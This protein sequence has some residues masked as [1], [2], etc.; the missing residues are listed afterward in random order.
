MKRIA[1]TII[2][3]LLTV[4]SFAQNNNRGKDYDWANFTKYE[5]AN[6]EV[7]T[8][9]VVVFMG[10]SITEY[11]VSQDPDFFI[12]NNFIGRGI[13]GQV[14]MQMLSRFQRDVIELHPKVVVINS[15]TNDIAKNNGNI[16][17]ENVVSGIQSMCELARMHG[18]TPVIASVLPCNRF[19]W[20]QEA[21]PAQDII[22]LNKLI[23]A[24][25]DAAGIM[26]VDYHT[27]MRA[28]DGSLPEVYT[29][30]GC[31]PIIAGYKKMESIVLPYIQKALAL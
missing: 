8:N 11:W 6:A 28:A 4:A 29:Q 10:D 2:M 25:A 16:K 15:G 26:Y 12:S 19:F 13:S 22:A 7:T 31:H 3:S 27:E 30:D 5:A 23:K 21:R 18:I 9:P 1:L 17:P 14:T 20:N 24:Y